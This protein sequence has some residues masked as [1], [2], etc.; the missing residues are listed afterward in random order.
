MAYIIRPV[1]PE[2]GMGIGFVRVTTWRVAYTGLI[3]DEFLRQMDIEVDGR[4]WTNGIS[5]LADTGRCG[6]VAEDS[7]T[8]QVVGFCLAGPERTGDV[9]YPG[10]I[11]ALYIL[12]EYQRQKIGQ[13][14]VHAATGWLK[15]RGFATMI[16]Y[17]LRD[18][19]PSR[20]FYEA[21][22]GTAVREKKQEIG[23][24]L[25]VEVGYGYRLMED[26]CG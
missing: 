14:L 3:S 15:N 22:G 4:R 7:A 8:G 23:G 10:E 20:R 17:V 12:P 21:L 19:H 5:Q 9:E 18:N 13:S 26:P 2:D 24:M 11:Y 6:F 1:K 16:I 25:L